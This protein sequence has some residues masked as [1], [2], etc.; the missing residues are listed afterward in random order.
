VKPEG[1]NCWVPP[2]LI[3]LKKWD[4]HWLGLAH[5]MS[6]VSKDP[7]TKVGAVITRPDMTLAAVGFNGFARGMC[8]HEHLYE[9]REEKYSRII[10]G[11]MNA[12]LNAHGPVDGCTL[13]TTPF[14]PCERCAVM[15][16]QSGIRRVV[17]PTLPEH[18]K[19]RWGTSLAKTSEF[20]KEADVTFDLVDVNLDEILM[21]KE[22]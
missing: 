15:V 3:R 18:L 7:S 13:Y 1:V 19:E 17:A 6:R 22:K 8:D 21:P 4:R 5:Y 9:N 14:A 2:D 16:I 20:F 10:H 11:E 12:I